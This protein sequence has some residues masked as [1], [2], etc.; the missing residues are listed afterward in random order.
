MFYRTWNPGIIPHKLQDIDVHKIST[1]SR[2]DDC[3]EQC[4]KESHKAYCNDRGGDHSSIHTAVH[5][6]GTDHYKTL[7]TYYVCSAL[8]RAA[9]REDSPCQNGI[10]GYMCANKL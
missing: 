9:C 5:K 6:E 2:S 1:S 4:H 3:K 8:H 10:V 7:G